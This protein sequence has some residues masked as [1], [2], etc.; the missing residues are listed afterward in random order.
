MKCVV[1]GVKGWDIEPGRTDVCGH[2]RLRTH[3][4]E[5]KIKIKKRWWWWW[6]GRRCNPRLQG[7][8]HV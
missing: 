5:S 6:E 4:G 1:A 7:V 3:Y 2:W 8:G